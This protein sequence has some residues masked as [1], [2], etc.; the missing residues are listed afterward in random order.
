MSGY[1]LVLLQ[2]QAS[3][4]T[5]MRIGQL[6][7]RAACTVEAIRFYERAGLLP[8]PGRSG[9]NY[10]TYSSEDANR[11]VFI[12]NC[13]AL[14]IPVADIRVL[15]GCRGIP[16]ADCAHVNALVDMHIRRLEEQIRSLKELDRQL[17]TIRQLCDDSRNPEHR[18]GTCGI[19]EILGK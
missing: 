18:A 9:G 6:A 2:S 3:R 5:E 15:L 13:R 19:I 8:Q 1:T 11:L 10:R 12:R 16:D 4:G 14:G 7:R 17:R